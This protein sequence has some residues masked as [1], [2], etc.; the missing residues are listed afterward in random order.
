MCGTS[1]HDVINAVKIL[2]ITSPRNVG[3]S[4]CAPH[5]EREVYLSH[6]LEQLNS[7]MQGRDQ[8]RPFLL[9]IGGEGRYP[10]AWNLNPSKVKTLGRDRGQPI[11]RR[12]A[13]RAEAIPLPDQSV[14][15][16]IVERSPLRVV[17][18]HEIARVIAMD[19][20]IILR[21]APHRNCDPH[22]LAK[23]ILPG[24]V[25]TRI[26]RLGW[27]EFQETEFRQA[28]HQSKTI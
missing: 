24:T 10:K 3:V 1:L 4:S 12:I 22:F 14:D 28:F 21:H 16:V 25:S 23:Q 27:Q 7:L 15:T 8:R 19:G 18:L 2:R 26:W 17:A 20:M 6:P 5:A 13:G 11:P 9:D